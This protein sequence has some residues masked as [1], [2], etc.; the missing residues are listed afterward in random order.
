MK[1]RQERE[2]ERRIGGVTHTRTGWLR[3]LGDL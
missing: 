3:I 2:R 1:A